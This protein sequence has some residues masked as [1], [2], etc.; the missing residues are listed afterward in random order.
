MPPSNIIIAVT[1]KRV[2]RT[3]R[4]SVWKS[5][6]AESRVRTPSAAAGCLHTTH[7]RETVDAGGGPPKTQTTARGFGSDGGGARSIS[8]GRSIRIVCVV[9]RLRCVVFS[10]THAT[11][12][13][14]FWVW[15]SDNTSRVLFRR[16]WW[17]WWKCT[18][19]R[20]G[21]WKWIKEK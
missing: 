14:C 11:N 16:G 21:Y 8:D 6:G 1:S 13:L 9:E 4:R 7:A 19:R 12:Y 15:I 2:P 5:S 3:G 18:H 20:M 17:N 10:H